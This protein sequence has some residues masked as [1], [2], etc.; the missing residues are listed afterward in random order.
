ME[1]EP[2]SLHKKRNIFY[3]NGDVLFE[4]FNNGQKP[5][6][7]SYKEI[8]SNWIKL[9]ILKTDLTLHEQELFSKFIAYFCKNAKK[10]WKKHKGKIQGLN[11]QVQHSQ[12]LNKLIDETTFQC[13]CGDCLGNNS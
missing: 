7:D 11:M 10:I 1:N 4:M 12:F 8:V 5:N 2:S 9:N 3:T 6:T 13:S